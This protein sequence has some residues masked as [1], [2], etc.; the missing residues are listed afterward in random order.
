VR[1]VTEKTNI[2]G[3]SWNDEQVRETSKGRSLMYIISASM[4]FIYRIECYN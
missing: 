3:W 2:L 4:Y 1:D